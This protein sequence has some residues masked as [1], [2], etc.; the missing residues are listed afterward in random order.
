M[1]QGIHP[2]AA[3]V[4]PCAVDGDKSRAATTSKVPVGPAALVSGAGHAAARTAST[5]AAGAAPAAPH[6][7]VPEM[8]QHLE[9]EINKAPAP[10]S[11]TV[12]GGL[13]FVFDFEDPDTLQSH[14]SSGPTRTRS[15][16]VVKPKG[17]ATQALMHLL[18]A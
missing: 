11:G 12:S 18:M 5:T 3:A 8:L 10:P 9:S 15:R 2:A 6:I 17:P 13:G 4:P 14:G 1:Q 7:P 16:Q